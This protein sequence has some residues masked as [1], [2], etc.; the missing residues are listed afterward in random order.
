MVITAKFPGTCSDCK[1]R[2][3]RG[4]R[5]EWSKGEGAKHDA[6][7]N[8]TEA[9]TA[10]SVIAPCWKCKDPNGRFR[11]FGAATPVYCDDCYTVE[12]RKRK[13]L[14]PS[15]GDTMPRH[16]AAKGYQCDRCADRDEG[17]F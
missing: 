17:I 16:Y 9:Q 11:S 14:C 3:P 15:C 5:I 2:F 10:A 4:A 7:A 8:P 13:D 6:C 12:D 1:D